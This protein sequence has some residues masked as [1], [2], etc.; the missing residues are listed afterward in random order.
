MKSILLVCVVWIGISS[1]STTRQQR[2]E[3]RRMQHCERAA[4][5][6]GCDFSFP[7]DTAYVIRER[8]R[9]RDTTVTITL[10]G[11]TCYDSVSV[12]VPVWITTTKKVL[13]TQHARAEAW[14]D[15]GTLKLLLVQKEIAIQKTIASA[16]KEYTATHTTT[17]TAEKKVPYAVTTNHMNLFQQVFFWLGIG[18]SIWK[19]GVFLY[20]KNTLSILQTLIRRK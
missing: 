16:I 12:P 7:V 2:I 3:Q 10:P 14:I 17:I 15:K 1:C 19:L 11:E 4:Y 6:W 8:I 5:R 9:I 20:R 13:E 18:Y